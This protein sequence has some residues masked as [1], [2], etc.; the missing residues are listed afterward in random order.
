MKKITRKQI[1]INF[2][3]EGEPVFNIFCEKSGFRVCTTS[4]LI[5]V[6]MDNGGTQVVAKD[7][8]PLESLAVEVA[9]SDKHGQ[10]EDNKYYL[11]TCFI[12]YDDQKGVVVEEVGHRVKKFFFLKKIRYNQMKK[13]AISIMEELHQ[14]L[15]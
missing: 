3:S 9:Y 8:S 12:K 1:E 5:G 6:R 15:K 7:V 10:S 11:V 2:P 14:E 13:I 4:R